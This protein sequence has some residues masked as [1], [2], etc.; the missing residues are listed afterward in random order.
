[1]YLGRTVSNIIFKGPHQRTL[2]SFAEDG[3]ATPQIGTL[4]I[5]HVSN[6]LLVSPSN[7]L[8]FG[9]KMTTTPPPLRRR[10]SSTST[11]FNGQD[12]HITYAANAVRCVKNEIHNMLSALRHHG[13]GGYTSNWTTEERFEREILADQESPVLRSFKDL[14]SYLDGFDDLQRASAVRYLTP[15]L[16]IVRSDKADA[17]ITMTALQSLNK[18]LLY[19]FISDR[20]PGA[21]QAINDL[22]HT[23]PRCR[24]Y[25]DAVLM[26][27]LDVIDLCVQNTAG[28]LIS[29]DNMYNLFQVCF[30]FC[31]DQRQ[32]YPKLLQ[33]SAGS[34]LAHIIIRL[35]SRL[36]ELIHEEA[37]APV[38]P[39]SSTVPRPNEGP[40]NDAPVL[41]PYGSNCLYR[42]IQFLVSHANPRPNTTTK[43][44]ERGGRRSSSSSSSSSSFSSSSSSSSTADGRVLRRLQ[45][46]ALGMLNTVLETAGEHLGLHGGIIELI[47]G[48]LCKYLLQSSQTDDPIL[49][50]LVLR[51]IFN[52]VRGEITGVCLYVATTGDL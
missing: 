45:I 49:L 47:Q 9:D 32:S 30:G 46:L 24:R 51:T 37:D 36:G 10:S 14:Q 3:D 29:G 50:S 8:W 7:H 27:L 19:G 25:T 21:A 26:I 44:G 16:D 5:K 33:Q 34:T 42:L 31:Q 17:T 6:P 2:V 12:Q 41:K 52:M 13:R 43:R 11:I 1:M 28:R 35:Y 39:Y 4:S 40:K 48:N 15:F 23:L 38:P 18:F 20:S 22:A